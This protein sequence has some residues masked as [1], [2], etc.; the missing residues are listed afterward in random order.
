MQTLSWTAEEEA[1]ISTIQEAECVP[2]IGA[3][4]GMQRRKKASRLA[5]D[6][7]DWYAARLTDL[8]LLDFSV[9]VRRGTDW[10]LAVPI[11]GDRLGGDASFVSRQDAEAAAEKLKDKAGFPNVR[12]VFSRHRD[13]MHVVQWGKNAPEFDKSVPDAEAHDDRMRGKFYGYSAA[14]I[15]HHSIECHGT[16]AAAR[17]FRRCGNPQCTRDDGLPGSLVHLRADAL[18]CDDACRMAAK[19]SPRHE[20]Q[21]QNPQ[22]LCGVKPNKIDSLVVPPYPDDSAHFVRDKV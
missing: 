13:T 21:T 14:A 12:I 22:C 18:Y 10:V 5:G 16:E 17:V 20:K 1:I 3:I 11:Y 8:C 19:R 2:R 9:P 6:D 15:L 7:R 4:R